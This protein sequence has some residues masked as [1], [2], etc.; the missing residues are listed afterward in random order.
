M[1]LF[2]A[3][4]SLAF[5]VAFL[6]KNKKIGFWS[7]F[8]ISV[9][10]SPLV[11]LIVALVSD[12]VTTT[13]VYSRKCKFCG[14]EDKSGSQFCTACGK[15]RKGKTKEDYQALAN[16]PEYQKQLR[17]EAIRKGA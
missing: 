13:Y 17:E 12:P 16:D 10:L 8:I 7:T 6:G 1:F 5:L 3:W 11:G 9:L 15:D 14:F 4:I 2:V